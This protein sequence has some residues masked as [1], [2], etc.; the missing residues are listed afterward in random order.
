LTEERKLEII[1]ESA[2][3]ILEMKSSL[4]KYANDPLSND[5]CYHITGTLEQAITDLWHAM[6][7]HKVTASKFL[8]WVFGAQGAINRYYNEADDISNIPWIKWGRDNEP[9]CIEQYNNSNPDKITKCGC[10]VSKKEV[11]ILGQAHHMFARDFF[12][13]N[14]PHFFQINTLFSKKL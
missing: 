3:L 13:C 14:C 6:R 4:E 2:S 1:Q 9:V 10:F 5:F 8:E 11:N 12:P 7:V